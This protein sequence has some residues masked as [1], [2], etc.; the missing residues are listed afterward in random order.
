MDDCNKLN[1]GCRLAR[2][3]TFVDLPIKKKFRLFSFGVLFWFLV[4]AALTIGAMTTINMSYHRIVQHAVPQDRVLQMIIRNM[5]AVKLDAIQIVKLQEK[6]A[7]TLLADI[8][9]RRLQD[10]RSFAAA[11]ALGGG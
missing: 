4:M 9:Q 7:I 8:S 2:L 5:Q 3:I 1:V 10:I 6:E 11:L